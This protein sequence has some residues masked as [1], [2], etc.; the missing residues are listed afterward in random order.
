V[1]TGPT[2]NDPV[3]P[4]C[5]SFWGG[6]ASTFYWVDPA[7]ETSGVVMTQV[8]GGDVKSYWLAMMK[9]IYGASR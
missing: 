3:F 7:G 5:G 8:F 2:A 6:A 9:E 1:R 4:Q